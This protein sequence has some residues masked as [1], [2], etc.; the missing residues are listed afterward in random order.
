MSENV[1]RIE[2]AHPI[3]PESIETSLALRF[4][5]HTENM[6]LILFYG[7]S[8]NRMHEKIYSLHIRE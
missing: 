3:W 5:D 4:A 1:I 7:G 8:K 2:N 6:K